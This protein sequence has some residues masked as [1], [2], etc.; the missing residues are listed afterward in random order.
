M[1]HQTVPPPSLQM[2]E[3]IQQLLAQYEGLQYCHDLLA[4]VTT[5]QATLVSQHDTLTKTTAQLATL[6]QTL[7]DKEAAFDARMAHRREQTVRQLKEVQAVLERKQQDLDG[8][9]QKATQ[10]VLAHE[11]LIRE[12]Q[13]KLAQVQTEYQHVVTL[14]DTARTQHANFVKSL[15]GAV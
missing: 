6:D 9:S 11:Q 4:Q 8:W 10:D 13:E 2:L 14:L 3:A 15:A 5:A 1:T 12:R 7:K